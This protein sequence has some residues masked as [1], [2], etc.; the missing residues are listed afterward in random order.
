M[1]RFASAAAAIA[2]LAFAAPAQAVDRQPPEIRHQVLFEAVFG[3]PVPVRASI[4]DESEV[5]E[6]T[7]FYRAAGAKDFSPLSMKKKGK[8]DFEA[9][10][11]GSV[12]TADFEYF[13]EAYD[14]QG[15][16]PARLGSADAPLRVKAVAQLSPEARTATSSPPP[17]PPPAAQQTALPPPPPPPSDGSA[18]SRPVEPVPPEEHIHRVS[19]LLS[20]TDAGVRQGVGMSGEFRLVNKIG[21]AAHLGF[22]PDYVKGFVDSPFFDAGAQ[23]LFYAG[24]SFRHGMQLGFG[25]RE[26]MQSSGA[27]TDLTLFLLGYKLGFRFGLTLQ[28]QFSIGYMLNNAAVGMPTPAH[29][30]LDGSVGWS[31]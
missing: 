31:F 26:Q 17:P 13:I 19:V 2:A 25:V 18:K 7:V 3:E 5:F 20:L 24:G 14:A 16:G 27:G 29:A 11:P 12:S 8:A 4:I 21:L 6:P 15:N 9:V 1:L 30:S 23:F 22:Y 10:I 28:T